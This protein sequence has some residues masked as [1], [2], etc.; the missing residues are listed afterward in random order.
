[1]REI[2]ALQISDLHY[3]E[4]FLEMVDLATN[5][6]IDE[7][8]AWGAQL[9]VFAGDSF[10]ATIVLHHPAVRRLVQVVLRAAEHG[11]VLI[12]QGTFSHDR[13]GCLEI[14]K[15]LRTRYPI[16]VAE[17]AERLCYGNLKWHAAEDWCLRP[18]F[19]VCALPSVNR[20]EIQAKEAGTD[21][22]SYLDRQFAAWAPLNA[23]ARAADVPTILVSHGT[24]NGCI[25]ESKQAM[26]SPDHE[27]G[28]A[29]LFS[30]ETAAVMLGHIHAYQSWTKCPGRV[31]AAYEDEGE[32][33]PRIA[34]GGSIARLINGHD[35]QVGAIRWTIRPEGAQFTLFETPG[36]RLIDVEFDGPPDME[37]LAARL[38]ECRGAKVRVKYSVDEEHRGIIDR[39]GLEAMLAAAGL[40]SFKVEGHINPVQRTRAAGIAGMQ[41]TA[42]RLQRWCEYTQTPPGPLL[43]RLHILEST[44]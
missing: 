40:H 17:K 44:L 27:F 29:A 6:A 41:T 24:V 37:Q 2:K 43:E 8:I 28:A 4:R 22:A 15:H 7:G 14:F 31:W 10:D 23:E 16:H 32:F 25:T 38:R 33:R 39:P 13:P 9:Y 12:L 35:G 21:T 42:A 18:E 34:Y 36:H 30:A 20:A 3:C 11:P 26:V 5:A 19:I 1:M